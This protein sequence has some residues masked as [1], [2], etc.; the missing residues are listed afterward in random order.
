V[1]RKL[2]EKALTV[3]P[4]FQNPNRGL[5]PH[6]QNKF[7]RLKPSAV[8]AKDAGDA[9]ASSSKDFLLKLIRFGQIWL[10]L[11]KIE[12]KFGENVIKFRQNRNLASPTTSGLLRPCLHHLKTDE[13]TTAK[14]AVQ[15]RT[16]QV[17]LSKC[18]PRNHE[19]NWRSFVLPFT[20]KTERP[21][22]FDALQ[23]RKKL[24]HRA[25]GYAK[26]SKGHFQ[27]PF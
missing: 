16:V 9:A 15:L 6:T 26:T 5:S 23:F 13:L 11:G 19:K 10:D 4:Q 14:Q 20:R 17:V 25:E 1:T 8:G 22:D 21:L 7:I 3:F 12:A 27:Q 2:E 24:R 18:F